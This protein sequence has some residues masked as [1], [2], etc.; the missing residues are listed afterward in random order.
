MSSD[1]FSGN[2]L[3]KAGS[4]K[5]EYIESMHKRDELVSV[6]IGNKIAIPHGIDSLRFY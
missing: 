3:L 5:S 2:I 1:W 4:I 6:Y